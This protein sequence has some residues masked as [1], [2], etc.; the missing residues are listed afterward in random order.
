MQTTNSWRVYSTFL[1]CVS[2]LVIVFSLIVISVNNGLGNSMGGGLG[3]SI[4]AFFYLALS[5]IALISSIYIRRDKAWAKYVGIASLIIFL[6]VS[7]V[8][9]Y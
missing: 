4:S 5:L 9:K 3:N 1:F 6:I 8:F 7:I 2:I